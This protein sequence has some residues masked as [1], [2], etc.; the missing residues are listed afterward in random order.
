MA[1]PVDSTL[2]TLI[3]AEDEADTEAD[4][5]T[6]AKTGAETETETGVEIS[7]TGG[8]KKVEGADDTV[9]GVLGMMY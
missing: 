4:A 6:D 2:E 9:L 7:E 5:E 1:D 8:L 3:G